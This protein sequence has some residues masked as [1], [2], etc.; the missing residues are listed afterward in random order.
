GSDFFV[1]KN[2]F[3]MA[4]EVPNRAALGSNPK[5]G[6][7]ARVLLPTN[8]SVRNE[9]DDDDEEDDR[10]DRHDREERFSQIDRMGR[11]AINTVFNHGEDKNTFNHIDPRQ[12]RTTITVDPHPQASVTCLRSY[13]LA[14]E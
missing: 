2:V 4:L 14:L 5:I 7:W 13:E 3:G 8:G 12:D 1:D 6:I 9:Q 11:P 10:D